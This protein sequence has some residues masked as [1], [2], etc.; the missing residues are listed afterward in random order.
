MQAALLPFK[1]NPFSLAVT[2]YFVRDQKPQSSEVPR[3][4][5]R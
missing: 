2:L 3:Y 1:P 5:D 4:V